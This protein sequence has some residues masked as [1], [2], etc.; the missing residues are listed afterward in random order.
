MY[1][2]KSSFPF[3]KLTNTEPDESQPQL[4]ISPEAQRENFMSNG[5]IFVLFHYD[6]RRI[7]SN[8]FTLGKTP[9]K[10]HTVNLR[11]RNAQVDEGCYHIRVKV[12][13][14]HNEN[15]EASVL[16]QHL[17]EDDSHEQAHWA[18]QMALIV[19]L[20]ASLY[21]RLEHDIALYE[22]LNSGEQLDANHQHYTKKL[23]Q[24]LKNTL[25]YAKKTWP[26]MFTEEFQ[27]RISIRYG[28]LSKIE[29][30]FNAELTT[31]RSC[32]LTNQHIKDWLPELKKLDTSVSKDVNKESLKFTPLNV[33]K[34]KMA[35]DLNSQNQR[36]DSTKKVKPN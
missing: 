22:K 34:R 19:S 26:L 28:V 7:I 27:T 30:L 25:E 10:Q 6:K 15:V 35:S 14:G 24:K 13:G 36:L 1:K 5:L 23:I 9:E 32:F 21:R 8:Q 31:P 18:L 12:T 2:S 17:Q 3:S 16:G 11:R 20:S 33:L 4:A 29:K